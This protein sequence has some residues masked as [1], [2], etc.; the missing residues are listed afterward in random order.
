RQCQPWRRKRR[1]QPAPSSQRASSRQL[2]WEQRPSSPGPSSWPLPRRRRSSQ[3]LVDLLNLDEVCDGLDVTARLRVV[4]AD[5]AVADPLQTEAAQR[6][7][8]I[9]LLA[10]LGLD[11]GHLQTG[12]HQAPT[13]AAAAAAAF[14]SLRMMMSGTTA[15]YSRPRRAATAR[16]SSRLLSAATVACT[17][18]I[19]FDEPSDFDRTSWTPAHSSTA[20][21]GPPAITPVPA[22]AG[23][24]RTTPAAASP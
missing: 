12:S 15:S 3:P 13:F 17:M 22:A 9:L 5:G 20:R 21:T 19:V 8:L 24:S 14:A 18:L 10:H 4:G 16:G 23:R 7:T 1:P 2:P 11:L 6:V